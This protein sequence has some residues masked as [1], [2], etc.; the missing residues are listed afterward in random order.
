MDSADAW[1]HPE[2]FQ[3]DE[4]CTPKA[5]AGCPPDGFSADGQM[6]GNPLYDWD[7][8]KKTAYA[9][10]IERLS[11]CFELYDVVRIDHFRGFDEYYSIPYGDK[12]AVNGSWKKGP[13]MDLFHTIERRLAENP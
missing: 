10:W 7:Y 5:V 1:S 8:H 2:L 6:W 11:F 3:L 13:G 12:T 4:Q 9:W